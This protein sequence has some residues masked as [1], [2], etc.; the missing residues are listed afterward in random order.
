MKDNG[1]G[2]T[3]TETCATGHTGM[4]VDTAHQACTLINSF[5][6]LVIAGLECAG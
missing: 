3:Q 2:K 5:V 1:D 6:E 4:T